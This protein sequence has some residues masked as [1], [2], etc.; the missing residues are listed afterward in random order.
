MKERVVFWQTANGALVFENI[1]SK[2]YECLNIHV[3]L[4]AWVACLEY[5]TPDEHTMAFHKA[6][7]EY[8]INKP[9]SFAEELRINGWNPKGQRIR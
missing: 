9:T 6:Y 2:D 7:N 8:Y 5:N 4:N 3:M 1:D